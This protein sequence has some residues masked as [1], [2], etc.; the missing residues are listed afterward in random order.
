MREN[1]SDLLRALSGEAPTR[2]TPWRAVR[3]RLWLDHALWRSGVPLTDFERVYIRRARSASNLVPK[4]RA[5]TVLPTRASAVALERLLSGTFWIFDLPLFALLADEP[6][7]RRTLERL[8]NAFFGESWTGMP[9]WRLPVA[10]L[11]GTRVYC[12]SSPRELV[13]RGDIWGLCALI[14]TVRWAELEGD[15]LLHI[16]ASQD[17][18]R[19]LPALLREPWA[20]ASIRPLYDLIE[21]VRIRMPTP[22]PFSKRS[23]PRSKRWPPGQTLKR[24]RPDGRRDR[25]GRS[26]PIQTPSLPYD[27]FQPSRSRLGEEF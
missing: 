25:A 20:A 1:I 24:I 7:R 6:I 21:R 8:T 15:F 12:R 2:R 13:H 19:A 14:G 9:E 26:R 27:S 11:D 23:G 18:F 17:A 3:G 16:E 10:D 5:G 4:W 22:A